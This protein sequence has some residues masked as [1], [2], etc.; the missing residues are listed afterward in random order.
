MFY[1]YSWRRLV[2]SCLSIL[3]L[4]ALRCRPCWRFSCWVWT[5]SFIPAARTGCLFPICVL[6]LGDVSRQLQQSMIC[7]SF[8]FLRALW[9]SERVMKSWLN[10]VP[11]ALL[12][13][14]MK[15]KSSLLTLLGRTAFKDRIFW[16]SDL[17]FPLLENNKGLGLPLANLQQTFNPFIV[18]C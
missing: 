14:S 6:F 1:I 5:G 2:S 4:L 13:T 15:R 7:D 10:A 12:T 9:I 11:A 8:V 17:T 18:W 16:S 3:L